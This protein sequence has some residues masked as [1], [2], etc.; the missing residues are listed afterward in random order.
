[1]FVVMARVL[2]FELPTAP[3]DD[4]EAIALCRPL[5]RERHY[6]DDQERAEHWV[7]AAAK[8]LGRGD[9]RNAHKARLRKPRSGAGEATG[10]TL[11]PS[12]RGRSGGSS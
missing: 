5:L 6:A 2:G 12:L 4:A 8:V 1:M 3:P 10:T 9:S 11:C 7:R